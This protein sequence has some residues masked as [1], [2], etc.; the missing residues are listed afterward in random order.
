MIAQTSHVSLMG[1]R[2]LGNPEVKEEVSSTKSPPTTGVKSLKHIDR[3]LLLVEENKLTQLA[4][5]RSE[6]V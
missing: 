5:R 3:P 4:L 1:K 6:L 2:W